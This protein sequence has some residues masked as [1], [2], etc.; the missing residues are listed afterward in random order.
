MMDRE[1]ARNE[2]DSV[3][4]ATIIKILTAF[5]FFSRPG[6]Y[7]IPKLLDVGLAKRW[8]FIYFI[9]LFLKILI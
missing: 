3:I 5:P 2:V 7:L 8:R 6:A 1:S 4:E 9:F